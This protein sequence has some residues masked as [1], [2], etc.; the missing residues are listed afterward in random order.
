MRTFLLAVLFLVLIVLIWAFY[1]QAFTDN[2]IF[3]LALSAVGM[4]GYLIADYV[5]YRYKKSFEADQDMYKNEIASLKEEKDVFQKQ[6]SGAMPQAEVDALRKN[7]FHS[8]EE[9]RRIKGENMAQAGNLSA[10]NARLERILADYN[11]LKQDATVSTVSQSTELESFKET[12]AATKNKLTEL[13]T[14]N[15]KLKTELSIKTENNPS[16][17]V[18]HSVKSAKEEPLKF[19]NENQK[20]EVIKSH[21]S[22]THSGSEEGSQKIE[23]LEAQTPDNQIITPNIKTPN[24]AEDIETPP[25]VI[26]QEPHPVYESAE[27]LKV[28]EGIGPKIEMI[29]KEAG[30]DNWHQLAEANVNNLKG[31]L[32][33]AGSRF[34]LNDPSTWPDQA[35][36]LSEGNYDKFKELTDKLIGGKVAKP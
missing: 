35:R 31:I 24:V 20:V 4:C 34:R 9:N 36:L 15:E 22:A 5:F 21:R 6:I 18:E 3:V 12:L 33:K 11:K 2:T 28:V 17:F 1:K 14:E 10:V 32:E 23:I 8:E 26:H 25:E 30:I 29:L 27:D 7:L 19:L 13:A 16:H